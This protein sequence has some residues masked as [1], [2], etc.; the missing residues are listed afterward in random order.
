LHLTLFESI[1]LKQAVDVKLS[2]LEGA[3]VHALF[4]HVYH[5]GLLARHFL[6][7]VLDKT[8]RE[9]SELLE[10]EDEYTSL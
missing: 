4:L 6:E 3:L 7:L 2:K 10:S 9:G 5:R 1:L 8:G